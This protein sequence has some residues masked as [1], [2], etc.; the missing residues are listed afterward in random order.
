MLKLRFCWVCR[1][2]D[3]FLVVILGVL[4][5]VEMVELMEAAK[6]EEGCVENK[7]SAATTSSSVSE[8][9]F[10]FARMSPAASS[11]VASSSPSHR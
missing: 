8:G 4:F 11:L 1:V 9:G 10:G 2:L 7:Q 3:E 5:G 6:M